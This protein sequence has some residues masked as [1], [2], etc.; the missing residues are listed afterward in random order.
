[1]TEF[2]GI[3]N[4]AGFEFTNVAVVFPPDP[5]GTNLVGNITLPNPT[6][7]SLEL[8]RSPNIHP[9]TSIIS[10]IQILKGKRYS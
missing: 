5:D 7:I 2:L 6:V 8:V 3:N 4:L 10:D 1:M 9:R